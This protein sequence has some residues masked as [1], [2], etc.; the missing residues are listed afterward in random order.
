MSEPSRELTEA[1]E[2]ARKSLDQMCRERDEEYERLRAALFPFDEVR[3]VLWGASRA[4]ERIRLRCMV[5]GC[6]YGIAPGDEPKGACI[7]C[8]K[9]R[10]D[11]SVFGRSI[12]ESLP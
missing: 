12:L 3:R 2:M 8:G 6:R 1:V 7:Y 5:E 10:P 11:L 9:K 4:E